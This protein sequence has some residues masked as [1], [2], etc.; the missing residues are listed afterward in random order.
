[1]NIMNHKR[2]I[3]LAVATAFLVSGCGGGGTSGSTS[4]GDYTD[5]DEFPA[6]VNGYPITNF[7]KSGSGE[8]LDLVAYEC[9]SG[10]PEIEMTLTTEGHTEQN[11]GFA[12]SGVA[13][14]ADFCSFVISG[15]GEHVEPIVDIYILDW[16]N[17]PF[18]QTYPG[19]MYEVT[20]A[21]D[22]TDLEPHEFGEFG[23]G[24]IP[25]EEAEPVDIGAGDA[26]IIK[27]SFTIY[28]GESV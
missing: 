26:Y 16:S 7:L 4:G 10:D 2:G 27:G 3:C 22:Y 12:M 9:Y 1:M 28:R 25:F 20:M 18:E 17:Q 21:S 6:E 24:R 8:S 23:A 5:Y 19:W 13:G 14:E 15:V 11:G